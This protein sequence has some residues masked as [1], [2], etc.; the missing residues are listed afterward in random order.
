MEEL[1]R[2]IKNED[3]IFD[4]L[5][6]SSLDGLWYWD[7]ENP[8]NEWMNPKFWTTLGY[9]PAEMPHKSEA[10][11]SIIFEEDL[12]TSIDNFMK[13]CENPKHPYDQ[14]VR[15]LHKN[16]STVWIRCRGFAIRDNSGKPIRMLGSHIDITREKES[17]EKLK[18]QNR[19]QQSTIESYKDILIFSVDLNYRFQIFNQAFKSATLKAYGV[20]V[21]EGIYI[22]DC[23]T[24]SEDINK[25]R[26]NFARAL[27]GESHITYEEYGDLTRSYFETRYN[28]VLND[29]LEV[30]GVTV[31]SSDI[32]L[33]I[34][35]ENH[36]RS[37]TERLSLA[38][39]AGGVGIWDWDIVNDTLVWDDQMYRLYGI[40]PQAF[41][42]AYESWKSGLHP[43]DVEAG[44]QAIQAAIDG[45]KEFN[46]EFRVVWPDSSVHYI[47]GLAN[48]ERDTMGKAI[49]MIGTN[50]DITDIKKTEKQLQ[51]MNKELEAFSY[52][53]SHDL[54]APLRAVN[55]YSQILMED[56]GTTLDAE[57]QRICKII[58][59]EAARMNRL[60]D[61]LLSYSRLNRS[62]MYFSLI[63]MK[64]L[65]QTVFNELTQI[66]IAN[67]IEFLLGDLPDV[68]GDNVL[69]RQ[70]WVNLLSN[71]IKFTSK[72]EHP[73]IEILGEET[74][75][76][77]IYT[78]ID[79]GAGFD[80][81]YSDKLFGV[82]KRLHLESEFEGTG[83][84]LAI[85]KH[86]VIR[87]GGRVWAEGELNKGAKLYFALPK[88]GKMND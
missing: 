38:T 64:S 53:I 57:G 5:Q 84:G 80:M 25:I 3:Q 62:E 85:V 83:V 20:E 75:T 86:A 14:V 55:G 8:E 37:I 22:F 68:V 39:R 73:K 40:T 26:E 4:F 51:Y 72:T 47:R 13:H 21:K 46:I 66:G 71:A 18:I 23:I 56:Y 35:A 10:W 67:P 79:N 65:A 76:E 1:Y 48:V 11:K 45:A 32:T 81:K 33:R 78:V 69:I 17:E 59:N 74:E 58:T 34:K 19:I 54:R 88:K 42:G 87:N 24:S 52:S 36:L 15:Y 70:V 29:K 43:D 41:G 27:T 6:E 30:I 60:I 61:D 12:K 77:K 82:F 7:I 16:G 49:R 44:H 2:F 9:N 50:W 63:D 28:P 31:M